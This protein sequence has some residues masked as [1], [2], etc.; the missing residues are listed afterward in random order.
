VVRHDLVEVK[1]CGLGMRPL[2][3]KRLVG[4]GDPSVQHRSPRPLAVVRKGIVR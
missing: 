3:G 2:V 1:T 4:G